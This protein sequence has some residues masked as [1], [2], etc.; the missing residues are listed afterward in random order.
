MVEADR[1]REKMSHSISALENKISELEF[2]NSRT[3]D[4]NKGLL[5]TLE[6]ANID[7]CMSESR[8]RELQEELDVVHVSDYIQVHFCTFRYVSIG[9]R[10]RG[11]DT[12]QEELARISATAARTEVLE[13]QLAVLEAEQEELRNTVTTT[14]AEKRSAVLRWKKAERTLNEL[15][16]QVERIEVENQ[17]EKARSQNLLDRLEQKRVVD[18]KTGHSSPTALQDRTQL[19][20]F[21]KEIL[22]E[23]GHLQIGIT[24]LRDMLMASQEEVNR[25]REQL[26]E[27]GV[28]RDRSPLSQELG[29][30]PSTQTI[31]HHYHY[32]APTK[33]KG[34][35]KSI[36]R[37]PKKRR[38]PLGGEGFLSLERVGGS[39]PSAFSKRWSTGSRA[40]SGAASPGLTSPVSTFHESSIFDHAFAGPESSRPSSADSNYRAPP[41]QSKRSSTSSSKYARRS[42]SSFGIPPFSILHTTEE[43]P[44]DHDY[45]G[46][47]SPA[48]PIPTNKL[49]RAASHESMLSIMDLNLTTTSF[50]V[51]PALSSTASQQGK[52]KRTHTFAASVTPNHAQASVSPGMGIRVPSFGSGSGSSAYSRLLGLQGGA[53]AGSSPPAQRGALSSSLGVGAGWFWRWGGGPV[54]EGQK[55]MEERG[56]SVSGSETGRSSRMGGRIASGLSVLAGLVDEDLLKESLGEVQVMLG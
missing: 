55:N 39:P 49:R 18:P 9:G 26:Q 12:S 50:P 5:G 46:P 19:S 32:H 54:L 47:S 29:R 7:M 8:I 43:V 35:P 17:L 14:K 15:E 21:M 34:A 51:S 52:L 33:E 25:L 10:R 11:A 27:I 16:Q 23:N 38:G 28:Q 4:A 13:A 36:A 3:T 24:E 2:A 48:V 20:R 44:S 37:R 30:S 1:D 6:D 42:D 40:T 31:V 41:A 56:G 53:A 22:A 45:S